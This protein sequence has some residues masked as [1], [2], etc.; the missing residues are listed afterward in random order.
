MTSFVADVLATAGNICKL[1]RLNDY[2]QSSIPN[3]TP[4]N[5]KQIFLQP[6]IVAFVD[7]VF[8]SNT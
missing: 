1:S 8:G 5:L 4:M 2:G 7:I 3:A 6:E